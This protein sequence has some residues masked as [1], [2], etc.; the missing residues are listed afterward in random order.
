MDVFDPS[1]ALAMTRALVRGLAGLRIVAAD[2]NAY[3]RFGKV[4][5]QTAAPAAQLVFELLFSL[6]GQDLRTFRS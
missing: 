4:N 5:G 1:V 3:T 6:P 2:V